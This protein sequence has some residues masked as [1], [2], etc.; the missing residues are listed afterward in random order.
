MLLALFHKK[1]AEGGMSAGAGGKQGVSEPCTLKCSDARIDRCP[2]GSNFLA[3]FS[4]HPTIHL[5]NFFAISLPVPPSA[6]ASLFMARPG[7]LLLPTDV[8]EQAHGNSKLNAFR[9]PHETHV[10]DTPTSECRSETHK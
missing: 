10:C 1:L 8:G 9:E 6:L 2:E 3:G 7:K 4:R 5:V